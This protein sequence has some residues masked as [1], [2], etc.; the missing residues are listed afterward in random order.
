MFFSCTW[1]ISTKPTRTVKFV[2]G[3]SAISANSVSMTLGMTPRLVRPNEKALPIVYVF[4]LQRD[5]TYRFNGLCAGSSA[6]AITAV[7]QSNFQ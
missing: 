6:D 4:P 7:Q 5:V 1:W 3:R 2:S